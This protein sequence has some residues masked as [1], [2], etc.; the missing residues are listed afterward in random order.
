MRIVALSV[1]PLVAI[2][3]FSLALLA[4]PSA[5]AATTLAQAAGTTGRYFGVAYA[6][7]HA[8]DP[9]YSTLA[10]TQFNMVTPENEMK[11]DTVEASQNSFNYGPGDQ[12]VTFATSH[13]ERVRGHNLVWHSQLPSWV[14]NLSGTAAQSAMTNHITNEV[15][16]FKGKIYAWDVVNEPFNDD[17]TWR[18]D[19]FYNAYGGGP[20]YVAAALRAARAADPAAKLDLNDY[21]IEGSGAKADAMYSLAQTLLAQGAP[22]DGI[23]FET[24]LAVQYGFPT[25]MQANMQRFAA[26][27]LDVAVTELDVRMNLPE[28]AAQD[29]TQQQYYVNVIN[30]CKGVS[31]CVGWTMWGVSDNY[32]WVPSTFSGQGAALLW[33]TNEQVKQ[34]L[35]NAVIVALGGN[36]SSAPPSS[37]SPSRSASASASASASRS[38]SAS[39]SPSRS[40]SPSTST[41][42]GGCTATYTMVNQWP[43]G[44]QAN[45][46]VTNGSAARSSWTV[47]WSFPNGQTIT[48]LWNGSYTQSGAAVTVKNVSYNGSLGANGTTSFGFTGSWTGTNGSPSVLTCQ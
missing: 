10:G 38:A 14:S 7:A 6:T 28:T 16:H 27:G 32:S 31:R 23:G 3:G 17:G 43:G 46:T 11:W 2:A 37:A 13:N 9:T 24:H 39:A 34:A 12:V 25:N 29:T 42:P 5:Q 41:P 45:V 48:Q 18:Q 36:P 44:F 35:F 26:L 33:D 40:V 47:G 22:L 1:T 21:N 4:T 30:A 15:T 19:V 8:G 20:Q